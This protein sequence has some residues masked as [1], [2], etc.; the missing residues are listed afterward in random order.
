MCILQIGKKIC[1]KHKKTVDK[2]SKK[3]YIALMDSKQTKQDASTDRSEKLEMCEIAG[4]VSA[5]TRE[6]L[7]EGGEASDVAFAL[8]TV[9]TDMSLQVTDDALQVIPVL[10]QA[11]AFQAQRRLEENKE[12]LAE[13]AD[14]CQA[15]MSAKGATIH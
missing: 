13:G 7:E 1:N 9:A 2:D 8:T 14:V 5:L 11:I 15:E 12:G 10:L 3:L 6:L 4:R